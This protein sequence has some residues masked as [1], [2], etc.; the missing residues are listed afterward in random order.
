NLIFTDYL[1]FH[2][3]IDG[4]YITKIAIAELRNNS[5]V[6][7]PDNFAAF[8]NLIKDFSTRIGQTIKSSK[9]LAEMMASHPAYQAEVSEV[10]HTR[11]LDAPSGTAITLAEDLVRLIPGKRGWT[12][13]GEALPEE[14]KIVPERRGEVPGIHTIT[15]ESEDDL[16]SITHSAKNRRGFAL[17]A[18]LAAEFCLTHHGI[19]SM[20]DMLKF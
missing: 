16:I 2:L 10:H 14:V 3:Y 5:I 18:V 1:D 15:W 11:K 20:N 12:I 19:L 8:T 17:G 13:A 6:A 7:L 4:Q 9:K